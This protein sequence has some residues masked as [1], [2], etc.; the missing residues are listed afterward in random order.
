MSSAASGV[1]G[2]F[3]RHGRGTV[4]WGEGTPRLLLLHGLMDCSYV[5]ESFCAA[6]PPELPAIAVD[7]PGHGDAPAP[8]PSAAFRVCEMARAVTALLESGRIGPVAILGHSLGAHVAARVAIECSARVRGLFLI[9]G[10]PFADSPGA[11]AIRASLAALPR[12]YPSVA[13]YGQV[14][15]SSLPLVDERVV[16][17]LAPH[18]LK[19][20]HC[21]GFELKSDPRLPSQIEFDD[22]AS[23]IEIL[24]AVDC[25]CFVVRGAWSTV[26]SRQAAMRITTLMKRTT[27]HE[28]RSAGHA[29]P[30]ESP[31]P[32]AAFV[33]SAWQQIDAF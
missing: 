33:T 10:G 1:S 21:G 25:A 19:E 17:R 14:L 23:L 2:H 11:L 9:E 12:T 24:R 15:A 16:G 8:P 18:M 13:A 27:V 29:I 31:A 20:A 7:L 5:W 26:M 6:L 3:A 22:D 30:L 32:L 4:T 28:I